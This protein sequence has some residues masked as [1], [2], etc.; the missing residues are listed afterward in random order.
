MFTLNTES[1]NPLEQQIHSTLT[2]QFAQKP[3]LTIQ[4]AASSCGCS[5][6]KI[7]KYIKKLGFPSYKQYR[8]YMTG[9]SHAGE[10]RFDE[11]SRI[12]NFLTSFDL[13]IA[14]QFLD[15][16]AQYDK[17]LILGYGPSRYA[18]EYLEMR[19]RWNMNRN[20]VCL[21]DLTVM[22]ALI[23][24]NTLLIIFTTSGRFT[25]FE[26]VI[27]LVK[28]RGGKTIILIEEMNTEIYSDDATLI[29]FT[30]TRQTCSDVP[31]VK[32]RAIF[33]LFIEIVLQRYL[34]RQN[35]KEGT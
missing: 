3:D 4:E 15:T 26:D 14:D 1:L 27:K 5:A 8:Q 34:E 11:I 25:S 19:I 16:I 17:A 33:F 9:R 20:A 24:Q 31:Y 12:Q 35:A 2:I 10:K 23:D 29:Y 6:S 22:D 32:S 30:D 13:S 21:S 7:S 28:K 18:A